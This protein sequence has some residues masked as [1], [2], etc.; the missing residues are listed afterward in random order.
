M[1]SLYRC[2]LILLYLTS[3]SQ[4]L[5]RNEVNVHTTV[6]TRKVLGLLFFFRSCR[7]LSSISPSALSCRHSRNLTTSHARRR[8][9][10]RSTATTVRNSAKNRKHSRRTCDN[11]GHDVDWF[12][13]QESDEEPSTQKSLKRCPSACIF[14]GR[15][16]NKTTSSSKQRHQA[17]PG[18]EFCVVGSSTFL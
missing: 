1:D 16:N 6:H 8:Q 11:T 15:K 18:E 10:F 3:L 13:D 7:S 17:A 14:V 9:K 2:L 12:I 4:V 5:A